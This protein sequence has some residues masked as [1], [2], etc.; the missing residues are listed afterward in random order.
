M[1]SFVSALPEDHF[2]LIS[3]SHFHTPALIMIRIFRFKFM[4]LGTTVIVNEQCKFSYK[5]GDNIGKPVK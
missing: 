5:T 1:L 3:F 4:I 2:P